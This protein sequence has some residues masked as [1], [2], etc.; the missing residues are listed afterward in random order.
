MRIGLFNSTLAAV[1][2]V[3]CNYHA[4]HAI[5][6]RDFDIGADLS[7]VPKFLSQSTTSSSTYANADAMIQAMTY[8]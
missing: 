7:K 5:A 6:I 1:M 8:T 4:A 2:L 3:A